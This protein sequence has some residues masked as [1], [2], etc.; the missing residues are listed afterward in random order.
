MCQIAE[1]NGL[2]VK[3]ASHEVDIQKNGDAAGK[4][5]QTSKE[6]GFQLLMLD[7]PRCERW[8]SNATWMSRTGRCLGLTVD[9]L[10]V[11]GLLEY[12]CVFL[13]CTRVA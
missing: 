4:P 6:E 2:T 13:L 10:T 9:A 1:V 3:S 8:R 11:W 12:V 5:R 7:A